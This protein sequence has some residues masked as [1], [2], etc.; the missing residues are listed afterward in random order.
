MD[1]KSERP[2]KPKWLDATASKVWDVTCDELEKVPGLLIRADGGL[3]ALYSDCW[4]VYFRASK[5]IDA[6]G[7]TCVGSNGSVYQHPCVGLKNKMGDKISTLA[8][9]FGMSPEGRKRLAM[10]VA[11]SAWDPAAEFVR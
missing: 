7:L 4:S 11:D 6:E 9:Q 5:V 8:K 2:K 3:L 1:L 10:I